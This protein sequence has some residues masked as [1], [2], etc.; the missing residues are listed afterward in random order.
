MRGFSLAHLLIIIGTI[1]TA[2]VLFFV[3]YK[4]LDKFYIANDEKRTSDLKAIQSAVEKYY[5]DF[6]KYPPNPGDCKKNID[7]CRL[8]RLDA[9]IAN[10]GEGFNPYLEKLPKDPEGDNYAYYVS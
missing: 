3:I 9:S 10:W 4:P 5:A 2:V 1:A 6:R 8:T 7:M